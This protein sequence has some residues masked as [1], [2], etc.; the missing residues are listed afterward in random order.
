MKMY[1]I[2]KEETCGAGQERLAE[3][4][5]VDVDRLDESRRGGGRSCG[6]RDDGHAVAVDTPP[7]NRLCVYFSG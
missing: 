2:I 5:Q 7:L 3:F 1:L 6:R 4:I